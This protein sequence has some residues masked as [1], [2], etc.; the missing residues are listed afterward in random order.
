MEVWLTGFSCPNPSAAP[1]VSAQGNLTCSKVVSG[2]EVGYESAEVSF[3]DFSDEII[4]R[5]CSFRVRFFFGMQ[6]FGVR[7]SGFCGCL[8]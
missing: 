8:E 2:V 4:I 6:E 1:P 7:D 5:G 3:Y